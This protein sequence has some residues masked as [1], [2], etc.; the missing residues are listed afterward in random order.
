VAHCAAEIQ[1]VLGPVQ[2]LRFLANLLTQRAER[3]ER[4]KES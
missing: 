3:S 2:A 4:G 1:P